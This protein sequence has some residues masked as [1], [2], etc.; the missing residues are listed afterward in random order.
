M[1]GATSSRHNNTHALLRAL[2]ERQRSDG[3]P[4]RLVHSAACATTRTVGPTSDRD[5]ERGGRLGSCHGVGEGRGGRWELGGQS[6][7]RWA[8]LGRARLDTPAGQARWLRECAG[9]GGRRARPHLGEEL[10]F[11]TVSER[12]Y[13]ARPRAVV[14]RDEAPAAPRPSSICLAIQD[15]AS[16]ILIAHVAVGLIKVRHCQCSERMG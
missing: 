5:A 9:G 6:M 2:A 3:G 4:S 14:E 13:S 16:G 1:R 10:P 8:H 15:D 12:G 11:G 7:V